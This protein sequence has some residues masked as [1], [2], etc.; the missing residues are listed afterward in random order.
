MDFKDEKILM[1]LKIRNIRKEKGF[2]QEKLSEILNI[3]ISG[4]SKI[5]NGKC[6]PSV[7]T[8]YKIIKKLEISPN[9]LFNKSPSYLD[10]KENLT[11]EKI[12]KLSSK[13][14]EKVLK[15][16]EIIRGN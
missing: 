7:E 14:K 4:L 5:E 8:I 1:G 13:D 11:I 10:T 3:D 15:I 2:T 12:K 6:F 16:L 9:E